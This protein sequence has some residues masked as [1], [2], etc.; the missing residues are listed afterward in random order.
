MGGAAALPRPALIERVVDVQVTRH[1]HRGQRVDRIVSTGQPQLEARGAVHLEPPA[2]SGW[3]AVGQHQIRIRRCAVADAPR[4]GRA[5]RPQRRH[6]DVE[7]RQAAFRQA[8][9][10][11]ELLPR[12]RGLASQSFQMARARSG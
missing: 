5:R 1:R 7:H 6:V 3:T 2:I 10:E 9:Q 8:V 12:D 11:R 4:R